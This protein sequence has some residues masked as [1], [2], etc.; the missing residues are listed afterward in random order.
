MPTSYGKYSK[1]FKVTKSSVK[2]RHAKNSELERWLNNDSAARPKYDTGLT[3]ME[4]AK[5]LES[6]LH[7]A[8][9]TTNIHDNGI[10]FGGYNGFAYGDVMYHDDKVGVTM[11]SNVRQPGVVA[12]EAMRFYAQDDKLAGALFAWQSSVRTFGHANSDYFG[13]TDVTWDNG[14]LYDSRNKTWSKTQY[15]GVIDY[16]GAQ[17]EVGTYVKSYQHVERAD[18]KIFWFDEP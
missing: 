2:Y 11:N 9:D 15:G 13:F 8:V 1:T 16:S 18:F 10:Y 7:D 4:N 12:L 17:V 14:P 5:R 3:R 6:Y